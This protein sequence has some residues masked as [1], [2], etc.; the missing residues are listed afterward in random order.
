MS[1][2][3]AYNSSAI[4]KKEPNFIFAIAF[5]WGLVGVVI[6]SIF[7]S[8]V[9][10]TDSLSKFYLL[11][12]C[13]ATAAVLLSP[14]IYLIYKRRF[15]PFHPLVFPVWIYFFPGF[16]VGGIVLS[17]GLSNPYFLTFVQD[18][19]NDLPLTLAYVMIGFAG[20]TI[21][22]IIPYG[23]RIGAMIGNWLPAADWKT[24]QVPFP[25][26]FLLMLGI[27]N[28]IL[29]FVQG[30]LGYQ[31]INLEERGAFDGIVFLMSLFWQEATFLLCLY[32][33]RSKRMTVFN[34]LVT[35]V[36]FLTAF[37]RSAFQGNRGSLLSMFVLVSFAYVLSG[38]K[39]SIKHYSAGAV[40][41]TLAII[42]GMVY[43]T[44]FRNIKETEAQVGIG[45]YVEVVGKTFD[46]LAAKGI[47]SSLDT[48][49][50]A[51]TERIEAVSSLAV[52]VSNYEALAPYEEAWGINNNIMIDTVVFFIPRI[53]WPD[54][55]VGIEPHRYGDLYFN[56]G[57]N[58]FTMTPMG[59]LLRNFGPIGVPLGM[60]L[61]GFLIRVIYAALVENREFSFWRVTLFYMLFVSISFEGSFSLIVPTLFKFGTFSVIGLLI[62]AFF[63]GTGKGVVNSRRPV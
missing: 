16:V 57:E 1:I 49:F 19:E 10:F 45:D 21:G 13:F 15:E 55:P 4:P 59:D 17:M 20:L 53:V 22:F 32:L 40:I 11:P 62:V 27:A 58:S 3:R 7:L 12:W 60:I 39:I 54:K 2:S 46:T 29:G 41:V 28:T 30:I 61:L 23:R 50:T 38:K 26:L 25:T 14:S 48:G 44:T 34:V 43:G 6:L 47:G 36:V 24:D 42:I 56:Y 51:L 37:T 18:A 33:F 35:V 8:E 5:I 63:I 9:G 52:V 31:H